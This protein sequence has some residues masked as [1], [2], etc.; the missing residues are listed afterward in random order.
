MTRI[1]DC[2]L[3][4]ISMAGTSNRA[5]TVRECLKACEMVFVNTILDLLVLFF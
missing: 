5:I 2:H 4:F 1:I 3:L